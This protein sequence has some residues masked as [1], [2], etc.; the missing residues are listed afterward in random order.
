[1]KRTAIL[2]S[3]LF[4]ASSVGPVFANAEHH[5]TTERAAETQAAQTLSEGEVRK[6]DKEA[7]KLTIKHGPL[8]NLDMPA[9]T[10]VFRVR[11]PAMLDEVKV[12]DAI[13]FKAEQVDGNLTVTRLEP[14]R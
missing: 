12:G 11:D 1:M 4:V 14:A 9:M 2:I 7:G 8:L 13:H 10:M 6:I 5:P 3:S